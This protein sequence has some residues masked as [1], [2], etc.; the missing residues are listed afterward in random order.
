MTRIGKIL[1][2]NE[3]SPILITPNVVRLLLKA[4]INDDSRVQKLLNIIAS[5]TPI[6]REICV[7][8]WVETSRTVNSIKTPSIIQRNG[9][10]IY[11]RPSAHKI[12]YKLIWVK[13]VN[14][15]GVKILPESAT[16]KCYN[17]DEIDKLK[18]DL[19]SASKMLIGILKTLDQEQDSEHVEVKDKSPRK[20]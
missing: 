6:W 19:I 2:N 10:N 1:K 18:V 5:S 7:E 8:L 9:V 20:T 14:Y 16:R 4:K 17:K 3:F 12:I 15:A 11:A 13:V